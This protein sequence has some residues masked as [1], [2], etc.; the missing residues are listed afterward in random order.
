MS[1]DNDLQRVTAF[2]EENMGNEHHEISGMCRN[3]ESEE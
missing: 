3:L 1:E 2:D